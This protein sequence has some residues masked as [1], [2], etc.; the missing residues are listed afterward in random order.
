MIV[1]VSAL[2]ACD[3]DY[4]RL[5]KS[6]LSKGTR[7]DSLLFDINFG[8]TREEYY[9]ICYDLNRKKLITQGIGFSVLYVIQDSLHQLAPENINMYFYPS[10]DSTSIVKGMDIEFTY[11]GWT[12]ERRELQS[13]SLRTIV[14]KLLEKWYKGNQFMMV[15]I[16][17]KET[18]IKIDAN[19]R[20]IVLLEDHRRVLV[21]VQDL[22]HPE[23]RHKGVDVNVDMERKTRG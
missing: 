12:A 21:H 20:I 2:S 5:V 4:T 19:R 22:L 14:I 10:F 6:E 3:S 9:G 16:D 17:D 11:P 8:T 1:L 18:P 23:Y 13:D 7:Q 15:K